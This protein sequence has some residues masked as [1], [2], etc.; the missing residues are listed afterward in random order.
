[1]SNTKA[2]ELFNVFVEAQNAL[3]ELPEI[4]EKH[5]KLQADHEAAEKL[6][7]ELDQAKRQREADIADLQAKLSAKEAELAQ[8]TFRE[9]SVTSALE[10]VRGI[11]GGAVPQSASNE[12]SVGHSAPEVTQP[13]GERAADPTPSVEPQHVTVSTSSAAASDTAN[14]VGETDG[15]RAM[16]ESVHSPSGETSHTPAPSTTAG[17]TNA[18]TGNN[19]TG[20]STPTASETGHASHAPMDTRYWHKPRTMT[21]REWQAQGGEVPEWISSAQLDDVA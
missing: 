7:E 16:G 5:A 1:M 14:G 11:I 21:Y 17:E 3:N 15:Q 12:P 2:S 10:T 4:R 18:E 13:Q 9:R 20:E 19:A 6:I 8:A